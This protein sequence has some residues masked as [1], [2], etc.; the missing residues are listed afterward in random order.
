[1]A[2]LAILLKN[3][4][5]QIT[6]SDTE[7]YP[8]VS[9]K[10]NEWK[11]SYQSF[12]SESLSAA[13]Y[14]VIGNAISRGN[15]ELEYA[16]SHSL[17][18]YSM[19]EILHSFFLHGSKNIVVAGTHGKT[20]TTLLIDHL[21]REFGWQPGLFAGG[22][23]QNGAPAARSPLTSQPPTSQHK[24]TPSQTSMP[25]IKSAKRETFAS[26]ASF[27]SEASE[28]SPEF[29]IFILEGDEYDTAFFD[30]GPKFL[31]YFPYILIIT[32]LE[33]DHVDIYPSFQKYLEAFR[34]LIR[35]VAKDAMIIANGN[36]ADLCT[37][38]LEHSLSPT[39]FYCNEEVL[40]T[41]QK[42]VA[43]KNKKE[44][45]E[46]FQTYKYHDNSFPIFLEPNV[47]LDLPASLSGEINRQNLSAALLTISY[48]QKKRNNINKEKIKK[49]LKKKVVKKIKKEGK[50]DI[51]AT[52]PSSGCSLD[53]NLLQK[54][55]TSFTGAM[56]RQEQLVSL[57]T[58]QGRFVVLE[59]FAHHPT[60]VRGMIQM[61]RE[62]YPQSILYLF[63]EPRSNSAHH[64]SFEQDY[65]QALQAADQIYLCAVHK[66]E[67]FADTQRLDSHKLVKKINQTLSHQAGADA[68]SITDELSVAAELDEAQQKKLT[69]IRKFY[70]AKAYYSENPQLLFQCF[71]QEF[72]WPCLAHQPKEHA[73]LT[74][75]FAFLS[76]G[77]FG[78]ISR[79]T[80]QFLQD[81]LS[82]N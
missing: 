79:K 64:Q 12:H 40:P 31:H 55:I 25:P 35:M 13:D 39:C 17:P 14:I 75:V 52:Q 7:L 27:A 3:Q 81:Q 32:S 80:L 51:V 11:I 82:S 66:K 18:L 44:R 8:P 63:F 36:Y 60:A 61:V 76:N 9:E 15:P 45:T 24:I 59:D 21:C 34:L 47:C 57:E 43:Q 58:R 78:G 6:G 26:F 50:E 4:G 20:T 28:A 2:Q 5:Y 67:I 30:K 10:L 56:K 73:H 46:Q 68:N 74:H 65:L 42:Q 1:M 29:P 49:N 38:L 53:A 62:K 69:F 19:P 37:L 48:L 16:L 33:Y 77:A 23:F 70:S 54:A 22:F 41:L 71:Q 72:T